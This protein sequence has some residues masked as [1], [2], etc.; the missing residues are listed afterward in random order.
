MNH[1]SNSINFTNST[2]QIAGSLETLVQCRRLLEQ[3]G[4]TEDSDLAAE[5]IQ[6]VLRMAA[7]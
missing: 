6:A 1:S 5:L 7:D 3:V 2:S 4:I